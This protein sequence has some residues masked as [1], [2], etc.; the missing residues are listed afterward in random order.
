MRNEIARTNLDFFELGSLQAENLSHYTQI[1]I[2]S[3][4]SDRTRIAKLDALQKEN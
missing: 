4:L 1:Q 3:F 2:I